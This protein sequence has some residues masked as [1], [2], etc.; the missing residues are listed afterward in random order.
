MLQDAQNIE[1]G[2]G[3]QATLGRGI[4][5]GIVAVEV[6]ALVG[7]GDDKRA[8]MLAAGSNIAV[9]AMRPLAVL[10]EHVPNIAAAIE[11]LDYGSLV[12]V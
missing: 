10:F 5:E 1:W 3:I 12:G 9:G 11:R 7:T 4:M 2:P 8:C 6:Q